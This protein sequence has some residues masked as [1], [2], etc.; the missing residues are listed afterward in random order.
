ML[1]TKNEDY[2]REAQD[3]LREVETTVDV[4][5][6]ISRDTATLQRKMWQLVEMI[7][8][9]SIFEDRKSQEK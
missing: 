4:N 3:G 7:V 8:R 5:H 1:L 9:T 6:F 2:K